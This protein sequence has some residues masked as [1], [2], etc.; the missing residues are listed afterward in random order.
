MFQKFKVRAMLPESGEEVWLD[1]PEGV[2]LPVDGQGI[3]LPNTQTIYTVE[4]I[5]WEYAQTPFGVQ[6][7]ATMYL[8]QDFSF[9]W[10]DDE[11]VV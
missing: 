8:G 9:D 2:P 5:V 4:D 11:E 3:M 1:W 10:D 7:G 6:V